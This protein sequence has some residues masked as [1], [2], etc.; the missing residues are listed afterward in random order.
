M[1]FDD[2]IRMFVDVWMRDGNILLNVGPDQD[3]VIPEEAVARLQEIG[4]WMREN[5]ESIYGTRGGPFQ[6]VDD[7][8]GSTY[9][10]NKI[11]VHILDWDRFR[12]MRLPAIEGK[13]VNC[14][15][16]GSQPIEFEQTEDGISLSVP[17]RL[18]VV[19]DTIVVLE[20]DRQVT[21]PPQ[22]QISFTG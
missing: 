7:V 15:A 2:A 11:Y 17:E 3:G 5:G 6:P 10:E 14:R 21:Q 16:I 19:P 1:E 18:R 20:L 12:D 4:A 9:T 22:E 13:I 8:Y